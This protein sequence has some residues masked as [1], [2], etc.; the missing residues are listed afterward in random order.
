MPKS[1]SGSGASIV[2]VNGC[3]AVSPPGSAAVTWTVTVPTAIPRS[4]TV[5]PETVAVTTP[6]ALTCAVKVR[7]S[8][9]G[10]S[11]KSRYV[12]GIPTAHDQ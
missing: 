8:R 7:S 11:K 3:V 2:T 6:G 1:S 9:S 4:V 5:P 12:L 10:S